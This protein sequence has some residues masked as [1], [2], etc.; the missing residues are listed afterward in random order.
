[1]DPNI[2]LNGVGVPTHFMLIDFSNWHEILLEK[3]GKL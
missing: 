1:M 2:H 3:K